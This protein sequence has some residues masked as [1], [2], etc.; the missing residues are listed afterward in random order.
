MIGWELVLIISIGGIIVLIGRHLPSLLRPTSTDVSIVV[1][2]RI[3]NLPHVEAKISPTLSMPKESAET[4]I[5]VE[6]EIQQSAKLAKQVQT[7]LAEPIEMVSNGPSEAQGEEAFRNK[8][9][10][11]AAHIYEVLLKEQPNNPKFSN[12]LGIVY[13]EQ[14]K[15]HE[16][17]D[18]FRT[19]LRFDEQVA[20]R[21]ANL[22]MA[23]FALGH[24]L[25]AI[26]YV[27][28]AIALAPNTKKYTDLLET[29]ET[30]GN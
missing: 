2:D 28:R 9:Y 14:E 21:H 1:P 7:K 4:V 23:E 27:K 24:R 10:E 30:D 12:R 8:E 29:I 25:T 26:R 18:V 13:M 15:F 3:T 17:R 11:I 5:V 22:A 16:A 6:E 19:V 20:S